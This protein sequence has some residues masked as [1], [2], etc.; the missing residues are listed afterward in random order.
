MVTQEEEGKYLSGK[1]REE[2]Q[3]QVTKIKKGRQR[4]R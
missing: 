3:R 2:S 4:K 1:N